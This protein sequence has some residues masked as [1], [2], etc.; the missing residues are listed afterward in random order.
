[1]RHG[2]SR[3]HVCYGGRAQRSV[4]TA[5]AIR[6]PGHR[7]LPYFCPYA[8]HHDVRPTPGAASSPAFASVDEEGHLTSVHRPAE[9][10]RSSHPAL[11]VRRDHLRHACR[12]RLPPGVT[13]GYASKAFLCRAMARLADEEACTRCG[14]RGELHVALA[15]AW[16]RSGSFCTAQ[17]V[18]DEL[19]MALGRCRPHRH[20]LV[21]R[22]R[23]PGG[24]LESAAPGRTAQFLSGSRR[25]RSAHARVRAHRTGGLEVRLLR[26]FGRAAEAVAAWSSCPASSCRDP[27]AH[28]EPGL[29]RVVLRAGGRGARGF[30]ARSTCPS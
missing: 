19:A 3:A 29:R 21:R 12:K 15:P 25:R 14:V 9:L 27:C 1:L 11:R 16:R 13:C 7:M 26:L 20:R 10:S 18:G 17:Q 22:D 4:R 6:H 24:L 8:D 23:P 30:F 2:S 5:N 28:R